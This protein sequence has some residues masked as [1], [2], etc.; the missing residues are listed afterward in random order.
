MKTLAVN[1]DDAMDD[2]VRQFKGV[3]D[4]LKRAVG[5]SPSSAP[6]SQLADNRMSLSWNQEEIDNSN[7]HHRNPAGAHS[8]SD[9]DSNYED[10]PSSVNSA[11]HSDNE[12][13]N[14]GYGSNDIKLN[15]AYSGVDAQASQQTKKPTRANSDSSNMSSLNSFE[16]PAG[17]PPEWMPTNVSVPLLNLVD[18]VFQLKR[19]GWIRKQVLW[20]SKQIV[21]LVM[22]DAIDEW[23]LRQINWLRRDDI[24]VQGI[25]WI[26]DTL[27]PNGIFFTR[28]DGYQG[29]ADSSQFDKHLCGSSNQVI[30][31]RKDSASAFELQ[32]EASRN[33][34]EVKKLLLGGTPPTLVSIIGYKQY[35]RSARDM[36][37]FLQ[38]NVCVKQLAYAM[39]EQVVV[40]LF[41]ELNQLIQD[42]H[43]KGRKEQA[44]FT[45][46]L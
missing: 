35:R 26:Q 45:Y 2:I 10:P 7:L 25:H 5:T 14:S 31:N 17:I 46:Q 44:A 8:L 33:A 34:S 37:Y 6:S 38:S 4:G 16:D 18:K 1:V 21:Q 19:R 41:P 23:I 28:L 11:S 39:V 32:L 43:E 40:S 13:N 12:L 42:V 3:S 24:I 15:E 20:I 36:Y 9:G 29:N 30:G 22:E 27:W